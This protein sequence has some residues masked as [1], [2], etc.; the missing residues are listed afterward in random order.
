MPWLRSEGPTGARWENHARASGSVVEFATAAA[1][2]RCGCGRRICVAV[3][4]RP[5]G[6]RR[7]RACAGVAP[8]LLLWRAPAAARSAGLAPGYARRAALLD[9][10]GS[11]RAAARPDAGTRDGLPDEDDH[12]AGDAQ[13][14]GV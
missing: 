11:A 5:P 4:E 10:H 14:A 13:A 3:A 8:V 1:T 9:A 2:R 12:A 7:A 6:P